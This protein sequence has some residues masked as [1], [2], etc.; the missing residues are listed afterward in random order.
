MELPTHTLSE[1]AGQLVLAG[2]QPLV[3]KEFHAS[4]YLKGAYFRRYLCRIETKLQF[5]QRTQP[6]SAHLCFMSLVMVILM[7]S[8]DFKEP[9]LGSI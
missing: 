5:C 6:Y 9:K 7:L 2:R 8:T 3:Y 1:Q 4:V